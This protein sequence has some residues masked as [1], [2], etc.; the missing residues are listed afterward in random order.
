MSA[1]EFEVQ[2]AN[3]WDGKRMPENAVA[4]PKL[5]GI[6]AIFV[7][8][9]G[10][11]CC[12]SRNGNV[13]NN[14]GHIAA[15]LRNFDGWVLD[16]E[17]VDSNEVGE[18]GWG[19]AV[20]AARRAENGDTSLSFIVFDLLKGDEFD[21]RKCSRTLA[22]RKA[23]LKAKFPKDAC[24]VGLIPSFPVK[25]AAD[26]ER[27]MEKF[28]KHGLEGAMLKDL[29]KPYEFRRSSSWLKVK[30]FF[31]SDLKIVGFEEGKGRLKGM[32]GKFFVKTK[33]GDKVGVGT[34]FT[35]E[36]RR[37]FWKKRR[38][39][40]GKTIEVQYQSATGDSL[41]FPSFVRWRVDKD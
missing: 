12:Y 15:E 28:V 7:I 23:I 35:D 11:Y 3:E 38:S 13:L 16:G 36:Q 1:N 22:Q 4:E 14:V 18:K 30:R 17:L 9:N 2:L 19:G 10:R 34:G 27:L 29:D 40:I 37:E 31:T 32:L 8:A 41:R 25:T 20:S 26:V 24:F 39:M 21:S 6:R 5:D 33:K